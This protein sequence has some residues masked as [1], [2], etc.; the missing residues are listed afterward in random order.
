MWSRDSFPLS[1]FRIMALELSNSSSDV[2]RRYPLSDLKT[3]QNLN[4]VVLIGF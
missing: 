2:K 1:V 3:R 4:G